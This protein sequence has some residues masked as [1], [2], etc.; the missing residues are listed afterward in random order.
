MEK[1]AHIQLDESLAC[2]KAVIV[3]DPARVAKVG[4]YLDSVIHLADNREFRSIKGSYQG[5]EILVLSTGIGA[6]STAIALEEMNQVGVKEVVR[7]GSC[8]AMQKNIE[9]GELV[10][11]TGAVRDEGLTAKYVPEIYPAV[12]DSTLLQYAR[13]Q[14]PEAHFGIIRS[15][16]GFYMD[17]NEEI[18]RFWSEQGV[19]GADMET[20]CLFIVGALRGM[21]T[22]SIL[23]NVVLF[24]ADLNEGVNEL[25]N[26]ERNVAQG[27][28]ASI[29]LA[30]ELLTKGE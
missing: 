12:P 23:N 29:R 10:I 26:G 5:E 22:A 13:E 3:G 15:H 20:S 28:A 7:V 30:L 6:P 2:E 17:N 16:D 14:Q 18:E 9:L 1:Q 21:K 24:E 25:V 19:L 11:A 27:E 4:D 8:G